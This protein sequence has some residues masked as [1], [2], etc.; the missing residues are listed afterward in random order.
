MDDIERY[1]I[2]IK[3]HG[4][5]LCL[6]FV[7]STA[8]CPSPRLGSFRCMQFCA[9]ISLRT[10]PWFVTLIIL[11][12][13]FFDGIREGR[14]V[15]RERAIQWTANFLSNSFLFIILK[16]K[17]LKVKHL[18]RCNVSGDLSPGR[19]RLRTGGS[20]DKV[21]W[22]VASWGPHFSHRYWSLPVSSSTPQRR[23][24]DSSSVFNP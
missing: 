18:K 5:F 21:H 11:N 15:N 23:E 13:R 4:A 7:C 6:L 2:R 8:C 16:P 14:E 1:M 20:S 17:N 22:R 10:P 12:T 19:L 3:I 24:N 9:L